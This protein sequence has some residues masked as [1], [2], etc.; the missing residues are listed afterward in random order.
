MRVCVRFSYECAFL[1]IKSDFTM[2]QIRPLGPNP[3]VAF[4]S[5]AIFPGRVVQNP[6][7][8]TA[9]PTLP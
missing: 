1:T 9:S 5:L 2:F 3:R 4:T 7:T 6:F 8:A